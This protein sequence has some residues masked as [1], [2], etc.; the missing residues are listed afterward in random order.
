MAPDGGPPTSEAELLAQLPPT[1]A[2]GVFPRDVLPPNER[3]LF[4]TRPSYLGLYWGRTV[5][6]GLWVLLFVAAIFGIPAGAAAY[7]FFA[8]LFAVPILLAV[9]QWSRTAY[10]LSNQRVLKIAGLRG[11][12]F[13]E[14]MYSQVQNLV[15]EPGISGGLRFDATPVGQ[16]AGHFWAS[17]RRQIRWTALSGAPRVYGFVQDAFALGMRQAE[18]RQAFDS[19]WSQVAPVSLTCAYCG[20]TID[21]RSLDPRNPRCPTCSA[22]VAPPT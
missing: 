18:V 12:D 19:H 8:F 4:E 14:A 9:W 20:S 3:I 13:Q 22:P 15:L 2:P 7:A 5:F 11:S 21:L 1:N 10:A 6:F 16:P 17:G